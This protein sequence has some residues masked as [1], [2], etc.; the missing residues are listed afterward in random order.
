MVNGNEFGVYTS[1]LGF[2]DQDLG[3][4]VYG[5]GSKVNVLGFRVVLDEP[6][7]LLATDATIDVGVCIRR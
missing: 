5:L 1:H 4:R 6:L 3:S 2:Q 7:E